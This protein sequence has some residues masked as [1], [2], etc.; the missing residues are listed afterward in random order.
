MKEEVDTWLFEPEEGII[1]DVERHTY[2]FFD[3]NT[4]AETFYDQQKYG[5]CPNITKLARRYLATPI[6]SVY[7]ERLFSELS[8]IH[9]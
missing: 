2:D 8:L 1:E 4:V 9:I 7:S 6:S 3:W 5:R